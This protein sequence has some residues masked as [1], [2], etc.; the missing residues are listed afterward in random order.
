MRHAASDAYNA[1]ADATAY[2]VAVTDA[3]DAKARDTFT[4]RDTATAAA[5][6]VSIAAANAVRDAADD[7]YAAANAARDAA[8]NAAAAGDA[9]D[10]RD[11]TWANIGVDADRLEAFHDQESAHLALL[12]DPLWPVPQTEVFPRRWQVLQAELVAR[13]EDWDVWINWYER[14]LDGQ[15]T[16]FDL[17]PD[18]DEALVGKIALQGNNFWNREPALVNADIKAWLEEATPKPPPSIPSH[19]PASVKPVWRQ[20]KL[21]QDGSI[22]SVARPEVLDAMLRAIGA[23]LLELA[24]DLVNDTVKGNVDERA[25]ALL[26]RTSTQIGQGSAGRDNLF[27]LANRLLDLQ[28][29]APTVS[30]EW[31]RENGVRYH[32]LVLQLDNLLK[33]Y[34]ELRDY[35]EALPKPERSLEETKAIAEATADT[36]EALQSETASPVV[37]A[38]VTRGL[39][40]SQDFVNDDLGPWI[41]STDPWRKRTLGSIENMLGG[42]GNTLGELADRALKSLAAEPGKQVDKAGEH[43]VNTVAYVV[44]RLKTSAKASAGGAA[45]AACATQFEVLSHASMQ[46]GSLMAVLLYIYMS[47]SNS[48]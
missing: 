31:A 14:R 43:A 48:K 37:D 11:A 25:L 4:A 40:Q 33:T 15:P 47:K 39:K 24:D 22:E 9:R 29:Y 23:D 35:I 12:A 17:P 42:T 32:A 45:M 21:I 30:S 10:A 46:L 41:G 8:A 2:A 13:N 6:Y 27:R 18:A 36:L 34:P 1:A 7:A 44:K 16:D 28:L 5:A 19:Q 26:R 20:D 3:A 38:S